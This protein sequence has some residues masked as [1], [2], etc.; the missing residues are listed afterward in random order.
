MDLG[1]SNSGIRMDS[2]SV[3]SEGEP[4]MISTNNMISKSELNNNY[5]RERLHS[6]EERLHKSKDDIDRFYFNIDTKKGEVR[7]VVDNL[8]SQQESVESIEQVH[9]LDIEVEE[10]F[11]PVEMFNHEEGINPDTSITSSRKSAKD[12]RLA[13]KWVSNT[14]FYDSDGNPWQG[15]YKE[16][17]N[18][19]DEEYYGTFIL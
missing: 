3:S 7:E 4:F 11:T 13:G 12:V 16:E 1:M 15:D 19:F 17:I 6:D 18:K 10:S 5:D 14:I 2:N 8:N 9:N